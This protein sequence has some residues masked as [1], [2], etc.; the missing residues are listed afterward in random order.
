MGAPLRIGILYSTTGAYGAFGR[1]CRDGAELAAERLVGEGV[2]VELVVAD[3]Q[4]EA[5]R[6]VT[7]ARQ[8]LREKGCRHIIGTALS[9]ARKDVA[10]LVEKHDALLWYICPYEGFEANENII[11]TGA[12]PNQ[13]LL[14]LFD[15]LIPRHGGRVFLLGA[16]YVWGWE[17]N[18]L[19]RELLLASGGEV[20]G[21]RFLPIE[22][23]E[24]GRLIAEIRAQRPS[25]ILNN[26]IGPSSYAFLAAMSEL[27]RQDPAFRP[28]ACPVVSCDLTECELGEIAP[29]VAVGQL[30]AACYFDSLD[31]PEN[32]AFKA[33]AAARFGAGRRFSSFFSGAYAAVRLCA[34]A[35]RAAG[36]D[37][38]AEVRRAVCGKVHPTVQGP[39]RIDPRTNH[40]ALPFHLGRINGAGGFDVIASRPPIA[41]DP[42]LTGA[43]ASRAPHLRVVS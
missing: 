14:P 4:G 21:E 12:C 24:I 10:P 41:A 8:L 26:L 29:G 38:P 13:H 16:N 30:A 7:L 36:T 32:R 31:T 3:P 9:A 5:S 33:I 43:R 20:A 22:E 11:Y 40:A 18:R 27:A 28:E 6:Y 23:T 42:Y 25:F 39:I 1:E 34:E 35:I 37:E 2:P 17:M 15:H 19:A